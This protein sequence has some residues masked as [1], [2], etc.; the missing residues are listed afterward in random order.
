MNN[1]LQ[2]G[3]ELTGAQLPNELYTLH[4]IHEVEANSGVSELGSSGL[5]D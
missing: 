1:G 4:N 2:Q 3:H 5:D